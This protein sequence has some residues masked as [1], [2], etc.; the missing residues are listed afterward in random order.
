MSF[1]PDFT[2]FTRG[3]KRNPF[4]TSG[5]RYEKDSFSTCSTETGLHEP[6]GIKSNVRTLDHKLTLGTKNISVLWSRY[7]ITIWKR[8]ETAKWRW[9]LKSSVW[10]AGNIP[11]FPF[12][13]PTR[14]VSN[15]RLHLTVSCRFRNSSGIEIS[16]LS[17]SNGCTPL[18]KFIKSPLERTFYSAV[19]VVSRT[20]SESKT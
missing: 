17:S 9:D 4:R 15:P 20:K 8:Q 12:F 1:R 19:P 3:S 13:F 14:K 11:H 6:I 16:S 2:V 18:G 10:G 7:E 5:L